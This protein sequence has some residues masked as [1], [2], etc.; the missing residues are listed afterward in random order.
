MK[1]SVQHFNQGLLARV[2]HLGL[3]AG[4]SEGETPEQRATNK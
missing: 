4:S 2:E 1:Y 3:L